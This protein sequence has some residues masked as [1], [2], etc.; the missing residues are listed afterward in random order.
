M[1]DVLSE[2]FV[3]GGV[4]ALIGFSVGYSIKKALKILLFLTGAVVAFLYYLSYKG[5]ISF[6]SDAFLRWLAEKLSAAISE[7]GGLTSAIVEAAP[8][9]AG[10][11]LG[12]AVGFKKG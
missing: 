7:I 11:I 3:N 8:L 1:M 6:K 2:I 4:G 10:F 12:F 9:S 5:F